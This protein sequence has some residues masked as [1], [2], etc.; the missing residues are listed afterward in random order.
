[1]TT[2]L[3]NAIRGAAGQ[4]DYEKVSS[5]IY[6]GADVNCQDESG[7]SPLLLTAKFAKSSVKETLSV[8]LENGADLR[9]RVFTPNGYFN[10]VMFLDQ[11]SLEEDIVE[12]AIKLLEAYH[13]DR[14]PGWH[15]KIRE[16]KWRLK[17]IR[18]Q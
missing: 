1:M 13:I 9:K 2:L 17:Q 15:A 5:L 16:T 10:A 4:G 7:W 6:E 12:P 11:R 18:G 14:P 8:L 3:N